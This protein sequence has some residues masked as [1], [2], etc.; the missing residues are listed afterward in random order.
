M[1]TQQSQPVHVAD[2]PAAEL[3]GSGINSTGDPLVLPATDAA[4]ILPYPT[5]RYPLVPPAV[6]KDSKRPWNTM[7]KSK[8]TGDERV[9]LPSL[10]DRKRP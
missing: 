2:L 9:H 4:A 5:P 7:M 10:Q 6:S 3:G 8:S 1:H